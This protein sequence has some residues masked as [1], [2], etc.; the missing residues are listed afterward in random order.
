MTASLIPDTTDQL[1]DEERTESAPDA[2]QGEPQASDDLGPW[3]TKPI[4][5]VFR[6]IHQEVMRQERPARNR[7]QKAKYWG[8][9]RDGKGL[10]AKLQGIEKVEDRGLLKA[11][12][13]NDLGDAA[14][15]PN[16]ADDLCNKITAQIT[17]DAPVP[18]AQP[19]SDADEH[20]D[21]AEFA[22]TFLTA[23]GDESGTNDGQLLQMA[24]D[25]GCTRA[26]AFWHDYVDP[27]GNGWRPKTI[28]AHPEAVDANNP[29]VGPDGMPTT[30]Y[31]ERYVTA[32]GQFT[33]NALEADRQWLPKLRTKLLLPEHVR[34][35]PEVFDGEPEGVLILDWAP[36][37]ELESSLPETIGAMDDDQKAVLAAWRP[38][39]WKDL[40][41]PSS[42][43]T[44][45]TESGETKKGQD[46]DGSLPPD[47]LIFFYRVYRRSTPLYPKGCHLMVNG[48]EGGTELDRRPWCATIDQPDG[49]QKEECLEIPVTQVKQ[50][51][52]TVM[53]DP[54]GRAIIERFGASEKIRNM[55]FAGALELADIMAHPN[56]FLSGAST[57]QPY[58]LTM[59]DGTPI[60]V[61][62]KDDYPFYE[63]AP[64]ISPELSGLLDRLDKDMNS[65]SG[66]QESAQGTEDPNSQS[67]V[68][69]RAV[70]EQSLVALGVIYANAMNA[71]K[72]HWRIKLQLARA[73]MPIPQQ[74]SYVGD[75]GS[76][77]Q[78]EWSGTD[79]TGVKDVAIAKGTGTMMAPTAKNDELQRMQTNTWISPEDAGEVSRTG[80]SGVLGLEDSP[81]RQRVKRQIKAW[82]NGPPEQWAPAQPQV[83]PMTQQSAVDPMS[84]QPVMT[85]SWT[86]FDPRPNDEEPTVAKIR[87]TELTKLVSDTSYS[88]QPPEWRA[89]VDTEYAR[90]CYAAGIQTVRQ[91]F[92][93][94]QQ[95]VAAQAQQVQASTD[96]QHAKGE[97]SKAAEH[98]RK[99]E[100]AQTQGG[101]KQQADA[102]QQ[103]AA[104]QLQAQRDN[105]PTARGPA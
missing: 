77:Q 46:S 85:Q 31:V 49:T 41:P 21:A 60:T 17:V 88:K 23:D 64:T 2:E 71:V 11:W 100:M 81:H 66:L 14:P 92:E 47:T 50:L 43:I 35:L 80:A 65:A 105:L 62:S 48:A 5:Q 20:Q 102:Q 93:A 44:A 69:K 75:D 26:S 32:A 19:M 67:G 104:A 24:V 97:Q 42:S 9:V 52:D 90:M 37:C 7:F 63:P 86:P 95:Q 76:Y 84:G 51:H 83:D 1:P 13:P 70:I 74:L 22:T 68:A 18:D 36:I 16:K 8:W 45:G 39:R 72:R 28:K 56:V 91:Q 82:K 10:F 57:V 25:V 6:E 29:L 53:F 34:F 33:D 15:V 96:D 38:P 87:H 103:G 27:T 4:K 59:R 78:E 54:M 30:D 99:M 58:Q 3:L 89:L 98:G 94:Q 12:L 79:F 40:L 73:F 101:I 55:I 61:A